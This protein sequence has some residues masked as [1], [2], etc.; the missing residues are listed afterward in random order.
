MSEGKEILVV[1]VDFFV[2]VPKSIA[3]EIRN[4]RNTKLAG[5]DLSE[6]KLVDEHMKPVTDDAFVAGYDTT[7]IR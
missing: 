7:R 4:S 2:N 3:A 1:T 5:I 6:V